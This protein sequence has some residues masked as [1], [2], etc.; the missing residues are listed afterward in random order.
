MFVRQPQLW[1][2]DRAWFDQTRQHLVDTMRNF[3]RSHPLLPGIAKE[4][5][6]GRELGEAPP[7]VFDALLSEAKEVV[8]EGETVRLRTHKVVLKQ[9]EEQARAAIERAFEQAG[10]AVPAVPEVLAKSGV[11][12]GRARSLLQIL[13]REKCLIRISEDLVF[14]HS[15]VES[16]RHLLAARKATRF[17][18][19]NFKDWTGISRKYAIPLL[20]YLDRER[21]TRREGDERL[22]L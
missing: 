13:L 7:F 21:I 17:N 9:D 2:M 4:D 22:I 1:L 14:H 19:G 20:E 5:L 10:L 12:T 18:V 6:R 11:E 8:V 15:A 16:L 3:H